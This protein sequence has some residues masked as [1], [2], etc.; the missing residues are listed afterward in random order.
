MT[1]TNRWCMP[2]FSRNCREADIRY[3]RKSIKYTPQACTE[4]TKNRNRKSLQFFV[5]NVS[6]A[7]QTAM[8]ALFLEKSAKKNR[9]IASDFPSQ[10]EVARAFWGEGQFEGPKNRCGFLP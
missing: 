2:I 8:D 4:S 5:A 10:G 1:H 3:F 7:S 6:V 9:T